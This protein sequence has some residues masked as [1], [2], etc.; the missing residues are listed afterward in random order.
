MR[1]IYFAL[2]HKYA[3]T[4]LFLFGW[5]ATPIFIDVVKRYVNDQH[6]F[7]MI[8]SDVINEFVSNE[9]RQNEMMYRKIRIGGPGPYYEKNKNNIN[10]K[11]FLEKYISGNYLSIIPYLSVDDFNQV[12]PQNCAVKKVRNISECY[13]TV[14]P[15]FEEGHYMCVYIKYKI[16]YLDQKGNMKFLDEY[17]YENL[18]EINKYKFASFG[19]DSAAILELKKE[20]IKGHIREKWEIID[21]ID[22]TEN[23]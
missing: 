14:D 10:N 3:S 18:I 20:Y 7:K 17:A 23:K 19:K 21:W 9:R 11:K 22:R 2:R 6:L 13:F 4:F 12:N 5:L 16:R 1:I 8:C 15:P